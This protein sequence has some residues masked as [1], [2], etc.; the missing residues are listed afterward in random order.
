MHVKEKSDIIK[1]S[2][3][4]GTKRSL[5]FYSFWWFDQVVGDVP[6]ALRGLVTKNTGK[7]IRLYHGGGTG[8]VQ[9]VSRINISEG[10]S[11]TVIR[12]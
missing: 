2:A 3:M 6:E 1:K 12:L 11:I 8:R 5:G 10:I 4:K 7:H 9:K